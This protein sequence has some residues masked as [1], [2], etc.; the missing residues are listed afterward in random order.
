MKHFLKKLLFA[1]PL[2]LYLFSIA[3]DAAARP[4]L[5]IIIS[6]KYKGENCSSEGGWCIDINIWGE[7]IISQPG[8]TDVAGHLAELQVSDDGKT[9]TLTFID[10]K[11]PVKFDVFESLSNI[12]LSPEI[13]RLLGCNEVMLLAGKYK[14]DY[15]ANRGGTI[16]FNTRIR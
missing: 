3:T 10:S 8:S 14:V 4:K 11:N 6:T 15:S 2:F 5:Q 1:L 9:A 13:A 16:V 7:K 12:T